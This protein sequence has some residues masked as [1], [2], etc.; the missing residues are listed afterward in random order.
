VLRGR[1]GDKVAMPVV[2]PAAGLLS[3]LLGRRAPGA[4]SLGLSWAGLVEE[5]ISAAET[6]AMWGRFGL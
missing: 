1:F 5:L 2:A 4:G 3:G 6:R